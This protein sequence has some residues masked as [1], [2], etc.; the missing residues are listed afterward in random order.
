[1]QWAVR[2]PRPEPPCWAPAP[3][4]A[5]VSRVA[6]RIVDK[7]PREPSPVHGTSWGGYKGWLPI[8]ATLTIIGPGAVH[9][10]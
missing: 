9:G 10:P 6:V 2:G 3:P 5:S 8:T 4:R 1:M 7:S